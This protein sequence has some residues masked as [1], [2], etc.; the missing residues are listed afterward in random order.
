MSYSVFKVKVFDL[1]LEL[2]SSKT[3][4]SCSNAEAYAKQLRSE[5]NPNYG[6]VFVEN[7]QTV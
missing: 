4:L 1:N 7:V 6:K 5:H 2:L 3:F